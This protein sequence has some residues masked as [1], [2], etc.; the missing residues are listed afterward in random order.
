MQ[1]IVYGERITFLEILKYLF[2]CVLCNHLTME[3]SS[4]FKFNYIIKKK[5]NFR[6]HVKNI[7]YFLSVCLSVQT[8]LAF[9]SLLFYEYDL[10]NSF[11]KYIFTAIF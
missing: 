5:K 4:K 7:I 9:E 6:L 1:F 8:L 3:T 2:T 10:Y 11:L